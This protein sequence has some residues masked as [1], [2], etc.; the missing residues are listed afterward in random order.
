MQNMPLLHSTVSGETLL[1]ISF[2]NDVWNNILDIIW[3]V[4][5]RNEGYAKSY[6]KLLCVSRVSWITS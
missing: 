1:E 3:K 5:R 6:A 2:G 4:L